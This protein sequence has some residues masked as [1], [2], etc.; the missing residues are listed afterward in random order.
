[1]CLVFVDLYILFVISNFI[2]Y[3]SYTDVQIQSFAKCLARL[4]LLDL[5]SP[6]ILIL[7]IGKG[8][9]VILL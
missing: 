9:L 7:K 3:R 6:Y 1:M 5:V 2:V 8:S 4:L